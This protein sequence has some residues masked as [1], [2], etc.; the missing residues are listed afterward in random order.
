MSKWIEKLIAKKAN[1]CFFCKVKLTNENT[2]TLQYSSSD[3]IHTA[4][5]CSECAKT[6]NKLADLKDE[7]YDSRFNTI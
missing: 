3:G 2:F 6:F 4:K 1:E 5:M 7:A